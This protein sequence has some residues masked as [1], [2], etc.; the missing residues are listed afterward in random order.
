MHATLVTRD[1][2]TGLRRNPIR[3]PDGQPPDPFGCRWCGTPQYHHGRS[4]NA[5]AGMHGWERP[6]NAQ[7]LARMRARRAA[8]ITA[9]APRYHAT[10]RWTGIPGDPEDP[11]YEL[12]ADCGTE[13]CAQY[14]R[15]QQRRARA[16]TDPAAQ[17]CGGGWDTNP[18]WP[19]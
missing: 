7:I 14:L 16:L 11:G 15:I 1:P 17:S 4:Y 5:G 6:T 12:C 19:F 3:H 2:A 8:R 13:T 18:N 9:P 10:T